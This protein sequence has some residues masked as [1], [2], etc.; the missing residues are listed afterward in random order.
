MLQTFNEWLQENNLW[1]RHKELPSI[2][3]RTYYALP[4][5]EQ[6]E[7]FALYKNLTADDILDGFSYTI[8]GRGMKNP[9]ND[10]KIV[11]SIQMLVD[12]YP[13]NKTYQDALVKAMKNDY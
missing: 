6:I 11:N 9:D 10:K 1:E 3:R 8:I 13:E 4:T 12:R 2:F 5:S 7:E